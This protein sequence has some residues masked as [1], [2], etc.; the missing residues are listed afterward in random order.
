MNGDIIQIILFAAVAAFVIFRLRSVLG[1][2][3]G[4]EREQ[5]NPFA[6]PPQAPDS[7]N[8]PLPDVKPMA[9]ADVIKDVAGTPVEAGLTQIKLADRTFDAGHFVTGAKS[10]FEMIVEAFAKGDIGT[11]E[12]LLDADVEE[13]FVK[14]IKQRQANG[15][16][17]ETTL[18]GIKS[19][20]ITDA[21][22]DGRMARI[23]V[24]FVSEQVNVT[25]DK[26][27]RITDG[28][29]N[30]VDNLTDIWTFVRDTKS[31]GPAWLLFET[32]IP[33]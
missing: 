20:S 9:E 23:T 32:R 1:R 22:M 19:A 29:P 6:P 25:K 4:S 26:E 18:V 13:N 5:P 3:T 7:K 31:D 11:L 8:A 14:A 24:T 33:N 27:G 15:E 21:R 17:L 28:D 12:P 30:L 2:R 10:A 16:T